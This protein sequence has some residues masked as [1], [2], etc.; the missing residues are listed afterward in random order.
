M[1][2]SNAS[3]VPMVAALIVLFAVIVLG[4]ISFA[5]QGSIQF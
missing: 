2:W 1:D 3:G 4:S 5:F